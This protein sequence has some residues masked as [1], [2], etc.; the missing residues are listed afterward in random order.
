MLAFLPYFSSYTTE[1][2]MCFLPSPSW[3]TFAFPLL[4]SMSH[5][6]S[7]FFIMTEGSWSLKVRLCI[8]A[9]SWQLSHFFNSPGL[10]HGG[11]AILSTASQTYII[12]QC[13]ICWIIRRI[14]INSRCQSTPDLWLPMLPLL[15][16]CALIRFSCP[17]VCSPTLC[18]IPFAWMS[19]EGTSIFESG[20]SAMHDSCVKVPWAKLKS[21]YACLSIKVQGITGLSCGQNVIYLVRAN[22]L[23]WL[24]F[25]PNLFPWIIFKFKSFSLPLQSNSR[26]SECI[27]ERC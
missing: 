23:T 12:S 22:A 9:K 17:T 2:L 20:S 11:K 25:A 6:G 3:C 1:T 10:W 18:L 15:F 13:F 24:S 4:L 7:L 8:W 26:I 14:Q 21:G 16:P 19:N 5:C 27:K